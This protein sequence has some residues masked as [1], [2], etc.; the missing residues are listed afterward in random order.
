MNVLPITLFA[1]ERH[2]VNTPPFGGSWS[3]KVEY[4][5]LKV[6]FIQQLL[7]SEVLPDYEEMALDPGW[8]Y[9]AGLCRAVALFNVKQN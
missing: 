2:R 8:A 7:L 1:L 3:L 4:A 5:I 9:I 6:K